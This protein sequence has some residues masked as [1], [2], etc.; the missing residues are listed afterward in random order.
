MWAGS[1]SGYPIGV[2]TNDHTNDHTNDPDTAPEAA[3]ADQRDGDLDVG[4]VIEDAIEYFDDDDDAGDSPA[5][6]ADAPA[7]G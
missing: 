6:D 1:G 4:G 5:A 7:P 2:T 3:N